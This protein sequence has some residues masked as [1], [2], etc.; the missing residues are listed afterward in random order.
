MT[1]KRPVSIHG[2][3]RNYELYLFLIPG[4]IFIL[5]FDLL[6]MINITIAFKN[7]RPLLGLRGSPWIGFNNFTRL[8]S[9]AQILKVIRNTLEINL[10]KI[11]CIIPLPVFLAILINEMLFP[12]FKKGVQTIIYIPHFFTWVVVYSIFYIM[13]GSGG[14]I[15]TLIIGAGGRPVIF[16]INGNWVR[17]LL[18]ISDAWFSAGWGTIVY[19]A[20]IT[21]IDSELFD[22]ATVDGA[23]RFQKIQHITIPCLMPVLVLMTSIRLGNVMRS[24]FD[25]V[26]AFY[27]PSVYETVDIIGTYVYRTGIGQ[28]NFSYATAVGLFN[29]VI[30]LVMIVL[31]NILSRKVTG[32]SIW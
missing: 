25:Q 15:N 12:K 24:S 10:M 21:G 17:F 23:G 4:L 8:L 3:K 19:L 32:R 30:G 18:I 28:A 14:I 9:D 16:F 5:L 6:P 29:S 20:A 7:F 13:F 27:N 31:A 26:L 2:F 11:I 22:A 1:Y